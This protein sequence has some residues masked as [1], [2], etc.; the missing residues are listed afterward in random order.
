[1][2]SMA[3]PSNW[4]LGPTKAIRV[5]EALAGEALAWCHLQE[6][7]IAIFEARQDLMKLREANAGAKSKAF[8]SGK[9]GKRGRK[10]K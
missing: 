10:R 1:M 2:D 7:R 4:L 6:A 8:G 5:P 3:N 9:S